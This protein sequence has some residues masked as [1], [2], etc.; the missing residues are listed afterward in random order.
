[1]P[2][3]PAAPAGKPRPG[4][5]SIGRIRAVYFCLAVAIGATARAEEF[6]FESLR[7]L[8]ESR[9]ISSVDELVRA[10]PADLRAHYTLVFAS[11]SLQGASP[12]N[13]RAILFGSDAEFVVTFNGDPTARGNSA[14]ET[15]EFDPRSNNFQFREIQ[16]PADRGGQVLISEANSARCVACHGQPARPVWDNPP[17][18]P[19][20]YGERYGAGLSA[21]ESKGMREFLALQP[22]HARYQNLLGAASFAERRTYVASAHDVYNGVATTSPNAQLSALLT[23]LNVRSILSEM[24]SRPAF[25]AHRYAL[26]AAAEGSC[27]PLPDYYPESIR[28]AIADGLRAYRRMSAATGRLQASA[29]GARL[30]GANARYQRGAAGLE[31]LRFVAERSLELSTQQWT[32]ALERNTYDASSPEGAPTLAQVLFEWVAVTDE[33]LRGLHTYRSFTSDDR[34]CEHLR[35][36]S[37]RALEAWYT[38]HPLS[39]AAAAD[40]QLEPTV[41]RDSDASFPQNA[42][43]WRPEFLERCTACHNGEVAPF[44]PFADPDALAK[45]LVK[46][47]YPHGRLLDEVLYRLAPEAGAKSMPRGITI[48]AAQR[49]VL[50]EY[51]LALGQR[52]AMHSAL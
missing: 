44:I 1:V 45:C 23:R 14:V 39:E 3:R 52:G 26:L 33:E 21:A 7:G 43:S 47:S 48:T 49:R 28:D 9:G 37:V 41:A 18:W 10:L 35:R 36:Q 20:A 31:E 42:V 50:E 29:V 12:A 24:A 51:F 17:F 6:G 25:D 13:P 11:R 40:A 16:F 34:Y 19:G 38:A 5:S 22:R 30:A 2:K 27:G 32:L 15:M 4:G 46:G 8:I